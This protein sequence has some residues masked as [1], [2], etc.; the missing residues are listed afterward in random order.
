MQS[1]TTS[2]TMEYL[3]LSARLSI[4]LSRNFSSPLVDTAN[5]TDNKMFNLIFFYFFNILT[6]SVYLKK[7]SVLLQFLGIIISLCVVLMML[8][9]DPL[10]FLGTT[11]EH[12]PHVLVKMCPA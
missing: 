9:Y 4:N 7:V 3:F 5:G 8:C 11:T 6:I 2:L 10:L 1:K 12:F